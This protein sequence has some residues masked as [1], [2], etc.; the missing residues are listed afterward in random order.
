MKNYIKLLVPTLLLSTSVAFAQEEINDNE[1]VRQN[2]AEYSIV[3]LETEDNM[4]VLQ[5]TKAVYPVVFDESDAYKVNQERILVDPKLETTF[6]LDTDRDS[7]F[8][9]EITISYTKP[10]N[11][12]YDFMLT[13]DGLQVWA[14]KNGVYAKEIH[15]ID[16]K[17]M[18]KKVPMLSTKGMYNII[19]SNGETYEIEVT[20]MK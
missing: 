12:R 1:I 19:M 10:E 16:N 17:N 2:E 11:V 9:R 4:R 20:D 6:K 5:E 13:N 15:M 3:A 18:K 8:E 14:N 7:D